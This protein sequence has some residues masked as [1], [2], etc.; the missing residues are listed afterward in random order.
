MSTGWIRPVLG[1]A[2]S[3][4]VIHQV[5]FV[6]QCPL[7]ASLDSKT[8][9]PSKGSEAPSGVEGDAL[10]TLQA[11]HYKAATTARCARCNGSLPLPLHLAIIKNDHLMMFPPVVTWMC[12]VGLCGQMDIILK[13]FELVYNKHDFKLIVK[14][15]GK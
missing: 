6:S 4:V 5:V 3:Q 8:E 9:V 10:Y 11:Q 13:E 7:M 2:A 1:L 14:I 15:W 12:A